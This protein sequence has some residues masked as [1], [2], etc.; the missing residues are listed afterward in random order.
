MVVILG[1]L[2]GTGEH[3]T[4]RSGRF[5]EEYIHPPD[6]NTATSRTYTLYIYTLMFPPIP[7]YKIQKKAEHTK[8]I[9]GNNSW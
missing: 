4:R 9:R 2:G 7:Y 8:S 5:M 6:Y 1:N 3:S